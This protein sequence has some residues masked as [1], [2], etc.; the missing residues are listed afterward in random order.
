VPEMMKPTAIG[1]RNWLCAAATT[2]FS[3]AV[4]FNLKRVF[5]QEV[6][7]GPL[8]SATNLGALLIRDRAFVAEFVADPVRFLHARFELT[9]ANCAFLAHFAPQDLDSARQA[10]QLALNTN[11]PL[12]FQPAT[13]WLD[14]TRRIAVAATTA[15]RAA[16]ATA[17]QDVLRAAPR[18]PVT[19]LYPANACAQANQDAEMAARLAAQ[20]QAAG[21]SMSADD[22]RNLAATIAA[23]GPAAMAVA[24][25]VA[26]AIAGG[27]SVGAAVQQASQGTN[28]MSDVVKFLKLKLSRRMR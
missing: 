16:P 19:I 23:G 24:E 9:P 25:M 10:A 7:R 22:L 14:A 6:S 13:S 17:P 2:M 11:R 26:T 12:V 21:V 27:A 5:A 3:A 1:R 20:L 4:L 18:E 28:S 15:G 8:L